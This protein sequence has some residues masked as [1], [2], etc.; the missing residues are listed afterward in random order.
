M[1]GPS[2]NAVRIAA[3]R[4]DKERSARTGLLRST[5]AERNG[6][7]LGTA[8]D[9]FQR[10]GLGIDA[11]R[12]ALENVREQACGGR[13]TDHSVMAV[14]N[15]EAQTGMQ[16]YPTNGRNTVGQGWTWA[17]PDPRGRAIQL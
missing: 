11:W 16:G 2:R 7:M 6:G 15:G 10:V 8:E 1:A 9:A 14:P 13:R 3:W 4:R 12:P 5:S 17:H